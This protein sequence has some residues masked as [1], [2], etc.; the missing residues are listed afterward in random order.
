MPSN[1]L[2]FC[3]P[4]LLL[5]SVFPSIRVFSMSQVFASGGHST[6]ASASPSVL[7]MSIQNWF[8]LGGTGLISLLSKELSRVF[9]STTVWKHQFFTLC[10]LYGLILTS[11]QDYWENIT[12]TRR[13]FVDQVMSLL[14]NV[15]SRFVIAFL[16]RSKRLLISWLQSPSTVILEQW[17][18]SHATMS[19]YT[20]TITGN[21]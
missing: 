1:H 2:I 6:G 13:T 5:P 3:L 14:F 4:L 17:F 8:P 11:I 9:C 7:P 21:G 20:I 10:L 15:L 18:W 19:N 12:L 16:P